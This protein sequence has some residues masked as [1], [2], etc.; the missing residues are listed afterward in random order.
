MSP[1]LDIAVHLAQLGASV[2]V[3]IQTATRI[4]RAISRRG[5]NRRQP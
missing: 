2:L 5:Q 4:R 3:L 1:A